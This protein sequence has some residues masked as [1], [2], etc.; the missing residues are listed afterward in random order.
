[1]TEPTE[2][3][4]HFAGIM[5]TIGFSMGLLSLIVEYYNDVLL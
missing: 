4:T 3:L 2:V 1:M 5:I